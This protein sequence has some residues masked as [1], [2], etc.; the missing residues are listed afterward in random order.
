MDPNHRLKLTQVL[1]GNGLPIL[2][3]TKT[4][5]ENGTGDSFKLNGF[6]FDFQVAPEYFPY[7]YVDQN[8]NVVH[9]SDGR[10]AYDKYINSITPEEGDPNPFR[11]RLIASYRMGVKNYLRTV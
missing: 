9:S 6:T 4:M 8:L 5:M 3:S 2:E 1:T 11:T 7:V 10:A